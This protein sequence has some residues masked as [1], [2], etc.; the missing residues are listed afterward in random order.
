[1]LIAQISDL[2]VRGDHTP[3]SARVPTNTLLE[4]CVRHLN[5]LDPLPDVVLATGD[6]VDHGSDRDYQVL[7]EILAPV[8]MPV[9]C[10][11]LRR[12]EAANEFTIQNAV[13]RLRRQKKDPWADIG[14]VR[15]TV[16]AAARKKL[17]GLQ[18][19]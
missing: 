12:L 8:A 9:A 3:A 18:G 4:A 14:R 5:A 15:Q 10:D 17:E 1:M 2:H 19:S 13:E 6:L 16:S 7:R 11:D